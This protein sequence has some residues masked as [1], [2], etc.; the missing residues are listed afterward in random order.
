[1]AGSRAGSGWIHSSGLGNQAG[2]HTWDGAGSPAVDGCTGARLAAGCVAATRGATRLAAAGHTG[3]P[4]A[5]CRLAA[6]GAAVGHGVRGGG[7]IPVQIP[8]V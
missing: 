8:R 5:R 4:A 2:R 3:G 6:R 7:W 1:M